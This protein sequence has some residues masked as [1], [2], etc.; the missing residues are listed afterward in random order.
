MNT[1]QPF[2]NVRRL[3]GSLTQGIPLMLALIA[4]TGCPPDN[5]PLIEEKEQLKKQ[6]VKQETMM[7]TLQEGNRVLQEQV[8]RLNQELRNQELRNQELRD[9]QKSLARQ[10]K[11]SQQ[12]GKALATEKRH[13]LQ[14][15]A[16][17]TD[18]NQTFQKDNQKLQRENQKLKDNA[19]WLRRQREM[20]RKSLQ[21]NMQ[22]V[23]AKSL[24]HALPD[25]INA[26]RRALA[27]H[28]YAVMATMETDKKAVFVTERKT[29]ASL[30]IEV[31]GFRN[32]YL[33]ELESKA[34]DHTALKIKA[35]YEKVAQ[36]G[37]V[38]DVGDN[39]VEE[40]ENRLI[41][42]IQQALKKSTRKPDKKS[43]PRRA[44]R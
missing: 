44:E 17:L 37:K 10:L 41:Q 26:T 14:Q 22:T 40:I 30:L 9:K 11:R 24:T 29:S 4:S 43:V 33:V 35:Q 38:L 16:T 27:Q 34:N 19:Q 32:Q 25:V 42:A 5:A 36:G 28:G 39:E 15:V 3:T 23:N 1:D 31:A 13:L 7:T 20:F 6:I 18:D 2:Q 21:T 8:D 12:T